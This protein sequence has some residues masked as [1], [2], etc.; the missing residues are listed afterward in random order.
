MVQV[1]DRG[2][3]AGATVW[4]RASLTGVAK[5]SR[6]YVVLYSAG[7]AF[8]DDIQL[9]PGAT[10][11]SGP[12]AVQNGDFES[13]LSGPW[14]IPPLYSLTATSTEYQHAGSRSLHLISSGAP[15]GRDSIITQDLLPITTG[16]TYTLS[17]W[18]L[19]ATNS[20]ELAV[21]L[22]D[23]SLTIRTNLLYIRP[24]YY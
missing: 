2:R 18:Y 19:P 16:G 22:E 12:N 10:A 17:F 5:S 20:I 1:L 21:R 23:N 24:P 13:D 15:T 14:R 4:R 8:L 3:P 7:D 9:L 6:L 11:E